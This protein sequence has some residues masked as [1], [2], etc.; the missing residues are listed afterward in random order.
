MIRKRL[1]NASPRSAF[2]HAAAGNLNKHLQF[3]TD[4]LQQNSYLVGDAVSCADIA[5]ASHLSIIDYFGDMNWDH[6]DVIKQ[7]YAI[8]K[9]R[10]MFQEILKEYIPGFIPP[11]HY[12][13]LDF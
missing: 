7:Y 12:K 8:I 1:Y 9:S 3:L 2:C 10:P 4:S 13:Q 5:A 6:W 11:E